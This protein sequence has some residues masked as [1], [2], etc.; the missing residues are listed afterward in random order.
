DAGSKLVVTGDQRDEVEVVVARLQKRGSI[1]VAETQLIGS[2]WVAACTLPIKE[3]DA[4][5]TTTLKLA[6]LKT[7]AKPASPDPEF[8]DGCRVEEIGFKRIVT[9]PSKRAVE[10]RIAY[11]KQ[12]GAEL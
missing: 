10:T 2:S 3:S 9:G 4:D 7:E 8:S 6:D 11:L 12:F 5:T 1:P